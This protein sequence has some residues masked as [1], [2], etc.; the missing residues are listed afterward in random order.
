MSERPLRLAAFSDLHADLMPNGAAAHVLPKIAAAL[1]ASEVDVVLI[2]GDQVNH[3]SLLTRYLE[4]LAVGRRANLYVDGNHDVWLSEREMKRGESSF[5]AQ[6]KLAFAAEA[7]GFIYL[8][9]SPQTI[10]GWGFA[11]TNGWYDWSFAHP[12]IPH[13]PQMHATKRWMGEITWN[14]VRFARW[15]RNEGGVMRPYSDPEVAGLFLEQLRVDLS[16]LGVSTRGEGPPTVV[17]SHTLPYATLLRWRGYDQVWDF[18][19][20]F[21]GSAELGRVYDASSAIKL[22]VAGHTHTPA[23]EERVDR[24]VCVSPFGYM[25]FSHEFPAELTDRIALFDLYP[26]GRAVRIDAAVGVR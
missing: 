26:D 25:A 22:I 11:G 20:A 21:M 24:E 12:S 8:P 23:R 2:A 10:A 1:Q 9:T 3:H 5:A 14:D 7:A 19:N 4:P 17:A 18:N 13:T 16:A 6:T 15:T